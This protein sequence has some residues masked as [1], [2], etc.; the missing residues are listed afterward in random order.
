MPL[1]ERIAV[2]NKFLGLFE[3][4]KEEYAKQLTEEMGRPIKF[5]AG[6]MGGFL[7]RARYMVSIAKEK[8]GDVLLTDTDKEGFKRWIRK[9][10]LGVCVL[11]S[12]WNVRETIYP[13]D[14]SSRSCT[15]CWV[16]ASSAATCSRHQKYCSDFRVHVSMAVPLHDPSQRSDTC[17][18]S[19]Q[20]CNPEAF[21][22]NTVASRQHHCIAERSWFTSKCLSNPASLIRTNGSSRCTPQSQLR[23]LH[24][25]RQKRLSCGRECSWFKDRHV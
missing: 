21:A 7:E 8:L 23:L 20:F 10:A 9:E 15:F 13:C 14:N 6:E 5:S 16:H 1:D 22:A 12:A 25:K 11:I 4:H 3:Q 18:L 2:I 17:H 24:W 19:R